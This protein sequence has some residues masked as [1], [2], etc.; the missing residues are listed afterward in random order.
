LHDSSCPDT[1]LAA[2]LQPV[3]C[4]APD[5]STSP[6]LSCKPPRSRPVSSPAGETSA[7]IQRGSSSATSVT[8]SAPHI[9][10]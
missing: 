4:L 8:G 7:S 9:V 6:R 10:P 5:G 2:P 3:L 1:W